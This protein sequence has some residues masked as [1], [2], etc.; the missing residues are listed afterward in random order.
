MNARE[1]NRMKIPTLDWTVIKLAQRVQGKK[2][3][4]G[5]VETYARAILLATGGNANSAVEV[6][7]RAVSQLQVW[8]REQAEWCQ[9]HGPVCFCK[10]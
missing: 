9:T 10:L 3:T 4:S 7:R 2:L 6:A 1:Y 5:Q 8:E